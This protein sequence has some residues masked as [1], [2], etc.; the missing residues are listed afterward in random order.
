MLYSN[1][2]KY[3]GKDR[4]IPV[5]GGTRPYPLKHQITTAIPAAQCTHCHTRGKRIGTTF[6]GMIEFDYLKDRAAPPYDERGRQQEPLYTK[7]YMHIRKDVHFERGMDC[8]DCHTSIDVHGDGNL[9]PVTFYQVEV[10]CADCHG[11][12]D[13]YPWQLPIGYGTPV[14]MKGTRGTYKVGGKEYLLTS[15]G[16][17]KGSWIKK[18]RKAYVLSRFTGKKHEIPLLKQIK[19][20]DKF[21]T[22]QGKVAMVTTFNHLKKMECYACHSTWAPQCYGCHMR[23]D[24]G[25]KGTDWVT[26]AKKV[27][28]KTGRQT[29]VKKAGDLNPENRSFIRWES[30]I[31]GKNLKGRTSPVVPGCQ[32]FLTYVDEI[33]DIK[34]LNKYYKTSTGQPGPTLAPLQP[35]SNTLVARTCEDCHANPKALGFGTANSRSAAKLLKDEPMF[36]DLSKGVYGDIPGAR[37]GRWQVPKIPDYPY[38]P[39]QL[40]TRSGKQVNN[41]PLLEDRPLNS[42]ELGHLERE[43]SCVACHQYYKTPDWNR[44]IKMLGN[45]HKPE[46]H[47]KFL[48]EAVKLLMEK[49]KKMKKPEYIAPPHAHDE[50]EAHKHEAPEAEHEHKEG[51][52]EHKHEEPGH[53]DEHEE[54]GHTDEHGE[55]G[56]TDEH[57][58]P[59][60][61][62]E[63]AEPEHKHKEPESTE[64]HGH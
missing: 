52:P 37:T 3:E 41:M 36:Q 23:Y 24:R 12:P 58:E 1:D 44:M 51:E 29:L 19:L 32:V 56:H 14:T 11:T 22:Q 25:V 45:A 13:K 47:D 6:G 42:A 27:N 35:H 20:A 63:H 50:G 46:L 43:G 8:V 53:T 2:G 16:N 38:S 10:N 15:R 28:P 40:I 57:G 30:P 26:S 4:T 39:D 9:Y 60:H 54:P 21:K 55:P 62:N 33:G 48:A 61:K 17:V 49:A 31:L 7:E 18:G 64:K 34:A 5:T 59:G